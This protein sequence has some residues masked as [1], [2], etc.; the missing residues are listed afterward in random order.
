MVASNTGSQGRFATG[1]EGV[2]AV[3]GRGGSAL[4]VVAV[5]RGTAAARVAAV[6]QA[7]TPQ[8]N[9]PEAMITMIDIA[10]T[11]RPYGDG[12]L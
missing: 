7:T 10:S 12:S 9:S 3:A 6:R 8:P 11:S 5:L 4:V 2:P 1:G